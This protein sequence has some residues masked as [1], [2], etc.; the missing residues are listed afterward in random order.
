MSGCC[1]TSFNFG[2]QTTTSFQNSNYG[3]VGSVLPSSGLNQIWPLGPHPDPN[4][5]GL[6]D[7]TAAVVRTADASNNVK[8]TLIVG[9]T[10]PNDR[11]DISTA[12]F[13]EEKKKKEI[14]LKKV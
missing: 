14:E 3:S 7:Y 8:L 1:S 5:R 6:A 2:T 12:P 13:G 9:F 4:K 11:C 10:D